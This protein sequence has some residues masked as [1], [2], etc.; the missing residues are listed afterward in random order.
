MILFYYPVA[1][2][3]CF[4]WI[5][6][7]HRLIFDRFVS[8]NCWFSMCCANMDGSIVGKPCNAWTQ[9]DRRQ[10]QAQTMQ[11][12]FIEWLIEE[13]NEGWDS[14]ESCSL[15]QN[16]F[17][18]W[19]VSR[20]YGKCGRAGLIS[21]SQQFLLI[22]EG[23]SFEK[24]K[25]IWGRFHFTFKKN[26]KCEMDMILGWLPWGDEAFLFHGT[27]DWGEAWDTCKLKVGLNCLKEGLK[28]L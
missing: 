17:V 26:E 4:C 23:I 3:T 21:I 25:L 2:L 13:E 24:S 22:L 12:E 16:N 6:L 27:G 10:E 28:E 14:T 9:T 11:H 8:S 15:G 1:T 18:F 20:F 5:G 7:L 19:S